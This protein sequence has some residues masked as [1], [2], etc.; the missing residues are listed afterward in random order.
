M[1]VAVSAHQNAHGEFEA[2]TRPRART[3][4]SE[5]PPEPRT[6]SDIARLRAAQDSMN[7]VRVPVSQTEPPLPI[8]PWRRTFTTAAL[9]IMVAG[10]A[11]GIVASLRLRTSSPAARNA[12]EEQAAPA[13]A[14]APVYNTAPAVHPTPPPVP[15]PAASAVS[16]TPY[17]ISIDTLPPERVAAAP[18]SR[19]APSGTAARPR[20]PISTLAPTTAPV[21]P[22]APAPSPAPAVVYRNKTEEPAPRRSAASIT[23]DTQDEPAARAPAPATSDLP[24]AKTESEAWITEER[25]F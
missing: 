14:A 16:V 24:A 7:P 4:D 22:P 10:G 23:N 5:M 18:V 1:H 2:P 19:P 9:V 11:V 21:P 3:L 6:L 17:S 25:R 8:T 15:R 20:D 12:T 13:V